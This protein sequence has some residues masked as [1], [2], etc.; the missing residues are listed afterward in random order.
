MNKR[1][2][3]GAEHHLFGTGKTIDANGYGPV[4]YSKAS[5]VYKC[6]GC[7]ESKKGA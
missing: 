2:V 7:F 1:D 6:R 3:I 4:N 5:K